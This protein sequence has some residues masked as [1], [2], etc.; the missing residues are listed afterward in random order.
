MRKVFWYDPVGYSQVVANIS[1]LF[2]ASDSESLLANVMPTTDMAFGRGE[3]Y[4]ANFYHLKPDQRYEFS[5][6]G[7]VELS[8]ELSLNSDHSDMGNFTTSMPFSHIW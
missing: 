8:P 3:M 4:K 6:M 1:G 7:T 2:V 5:L